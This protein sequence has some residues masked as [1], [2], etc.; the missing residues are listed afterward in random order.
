MELFI[1]KA[2]KVI[3]ESQDYLNALE[4]K[5][6]TGKLRKVKYKE[7]VNFT[8]DHDL[9]INLRNYA[10]KHNLKMSNLVENLIRKELKKP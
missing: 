2:K 8:I 10:R 4:E 9:L 1:D 7:R 6:R 5:D 3:K